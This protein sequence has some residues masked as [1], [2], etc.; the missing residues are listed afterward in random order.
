MS[1]RVSLEKARRFSERN[2]MLQRMQQ[3]GMS[4][5]RSTRRQKK[6]IAMH[7]RQTSIIRRMVDRIK[8][9]GGSVPKHLKE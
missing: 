8:M 2:L 5:P 3:Q 1:R 4:L 6:H 9:T 7:K